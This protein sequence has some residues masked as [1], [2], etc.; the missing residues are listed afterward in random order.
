MLGM[1]LIMAGMLHLAPTPVLAEVKCVAKTVPKINVLPSKSRVSYDFTKTKAQLN[2][3]DVDT[4]SPY[5]PQHKTNVSGLMSGSIQVK[6][7][8]SFMHETYDQLDQGCIYLKSID[9]KIHIDPTIFIASEYPKGSCMHNAVLGHE[10][11]HVR[12]D[13]LIVNKY[14]NIVGKALYSMVKSQEAAFGPYEKARM[15]FVQQNIQNSLNTIVK[16]YNQKMNEERQQR[17]QAIDS[18]E[19]YESI[20]ERCPDKD[21]KKH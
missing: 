14:S 15:P 12:E 7:Q 21:K 18:L 4:V 19:E 20:G 11:K 13:Q 16:K 5:G 8:V 3:V 17:Q 10:R 9:V 2:S 1:E 6:H